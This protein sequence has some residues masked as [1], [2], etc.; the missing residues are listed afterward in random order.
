MNAVFTYAVRYQI[1]IKCVSPMRSGG[2]DRDTEVILRDWDSTPMIQGTS[3]TGAMRK[4]FETNIPSDTD[5]L[6]GSQEK[7]G[8]VT[9]SDVRFDKSSSTVIRPRLRIDGATGAAADKAKF[10][11]M[12]LETGTT[13]EFSIV[14]K[15]ISSEDQTKAIQ[16]LEL[17]FASMNAGYIRLGA[18]KSNGFGQVKLTSVKRHKYDMKNK[19]DRAA[20]LSETDGIEI[21]LPEAVSPAIVI[22]VVMETDALLVKTGTKKLISVS[23]AKKEKRPSVDVSI[24][25]AGRSIIPGSSIKGAVR[26][27][28]ERFAPF[29]NLSQDEISEL[30][31]RE[32]SPQDNGVAGKVYF[33]DAVFLEDPKKSTVQTRIRINRLTGSVM[34][35]A[36]VKEEVIGGSCKWDITLPSTVNQEKTGA[37]LLF[38]LRDLGIGLYSLGSGYAIGRGRP[39][40]LTV[41][42][43]SSVLTCKNGTAQIADHDGLFAKWIHALRGEPA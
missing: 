26:A 17:C 15:G 14:W 42:I 23:G 21:Q 25:E 34:D 22:H 39:T 30:F 40:K 11:M 9:V 32:S 24:E 20:W 10:D 6:F 33:S 36:M 27:Q 13:G 16:L 7:E 35:K 12:H 8:S 29:C 38:A 4:W 1:K 2:N 3:L 31:G 5:F 18:Q 28:I 37:I 43:G 19:D 41:H